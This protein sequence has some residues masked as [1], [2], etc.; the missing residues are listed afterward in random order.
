MSMEANQQS[1]LLRNTA[2]E[3]AAQGSDKFGTVP[4]D[5][6]EFR[7]ARN[8][9]DGF[10][11]VPQISERKEN[12]TLT[13]REA[14]RMFEAAGVAR[15]E[16]SII[17]WCQFNAQGVARL[18]AYFDPNERKYFITPQSVEL[19]IAEEEAKAAKKIESSESVRTIPNE[20]E[21]ELQEPGSGSDAGVRHVRDLERKVRDLEITNKVKDSFIE[22]L[23]NEREAH[24]EQLMTL[25][26]KVGELETKVPRVLDAPAEPPQVSEGQSGLSLG[27]PIEG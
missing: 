15:T 16:R 9:S 24:V 4:N 26:R 10:R 13:V 20:S 18:D 6:A 21:M 8:D 19:A 7:S 3:N 5:S 23:Q 25:S 27:P 2:G 14:A 12:H 17:N 22:L 11:T 1:D